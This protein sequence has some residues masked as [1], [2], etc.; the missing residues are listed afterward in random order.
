VGRLTSPS[1]VQC[2]EALRARRLPLDS[3]SVAEPYARKVE[4]R[5]A[6]DY[7]VAES[8]SYLDQ[9]DDSRVRMPGADEASAR[10][11][12]PLPEQGEGALEALRA[13]VERGLDGAIRSS[14]PR[15]FHFV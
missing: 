5:S 3:L 6:L 1:E 2:E 4:L 8:H 14:G 11:A 13:L 7:V 9:L 15:F 10:L 12:G